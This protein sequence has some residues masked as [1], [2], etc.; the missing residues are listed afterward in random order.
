MF[1]IFA[2]AERKKELFNIFMREM[3]KTIKMTVGKVD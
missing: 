1:K 3:R 2:V